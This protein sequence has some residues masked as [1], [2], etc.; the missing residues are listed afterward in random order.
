MRISVVR[1][2]ISKE[3]EL[4]N[5]NSAFTTLLSTKKHSLMFQLLPPGP[6]ICPNLL[7]NY[8]HTQ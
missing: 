3:Q 2:H 7:K 4:F 6:M 5:I 8:L 1:R